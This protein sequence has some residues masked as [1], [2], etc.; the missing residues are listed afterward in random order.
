MIT[1]LL[2]Y[3][4]FYIIFCLITLFT[5]LQGLRMIVQ[6]GKGIEPSIKIPKLPWQVYEQKQRMIRNA[7]DIL[8]NG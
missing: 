8:K 1:T 5:L 6:T 7:T 3:T 4:G 2:I